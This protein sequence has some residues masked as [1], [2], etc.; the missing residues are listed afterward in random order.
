M[1]ATED[2]D[3]AIRRVTQDRGRVYGDA[4]DNFRRASALMEVVDECGDPLV[5][6]ALR[7]ICMKMARLIH[8]PRHVDSLID[9]AGY[10]RTACMVIDRRQDKADELATRLREQLRQDMQKEMSRGQTDAPADGDADAAGPAVPG[11]DA[12][13][14]S[15]AG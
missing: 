7:M 14:G 15:G 8:S 6:V 12:R 11:P 5:R 1:Y 3:T 2:F 10:A 13:G 9:I 4:A